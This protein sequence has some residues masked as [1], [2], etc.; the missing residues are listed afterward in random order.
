MMPTRNLPRRP[1]RLVVNSQLNLVGVRLEARALF[2]FI[3]EPCGFT[4]KK[5]TLVLAEDVVEQVSK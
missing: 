1:T 4:T 3:A 2:N 5:I